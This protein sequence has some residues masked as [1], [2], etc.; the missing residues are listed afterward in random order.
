MSSGVDVDTSELDRELKRLGRRAIDYSPVTPVMAEILVGYVND[1]WDSAGRG[2]WPGL[3]ES[4]KKKRRGTSYQILK[5]TGRAAASVRG[6][7]DHESASAVTDTS[8]MVY[9]VSDQPRTMIPQRDPFDVLDVA[10]P[11]IEELL[12]DHIAGEKG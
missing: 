2:R 4:T 10:W 5:D 7:S 1:E 12:I 9:H 8:Y 3:A 11:E 6:D